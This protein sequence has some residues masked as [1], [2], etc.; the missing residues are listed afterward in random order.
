MD[1]P[2]AGARFHKLVSIMRTLRSPQGCAWDRAQTLESLRPFVLEETYELI[3]AIDR[4]DRSALGEELGDVLYEV[5]F[6]AQV[7]EEEG[8]LVL[9]DAIEAIADKLIRRHPH[10]FTPEGQPLNE[11]GISLTPNQVVAKWEELKAGERAASG[12]AGTT[13]L[14][15]VPRALPALL[16]A[17]E[18]SS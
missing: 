13:M 3:D 17:Y 2:D 10:V 16:R 7:A 11:G 6:L 8:S 18:L 14:S 4:G 5:V 9:G 12:R 1:A 15:G